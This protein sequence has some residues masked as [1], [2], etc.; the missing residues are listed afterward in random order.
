MF[1]LVFRSATFPS[2]G[3]T[4]TEELRSKP[5]GCFRSRKRGGLANNDPP[6]ISGLRNV[7]VETSLQETVT[8]KAG[9]FVTDRVEPDSVIV[10][11]VCKNR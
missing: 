7:V 10:E 8:Q 5:L 3:F 11:N 6:H 9:N 4:S 1:S 2:T